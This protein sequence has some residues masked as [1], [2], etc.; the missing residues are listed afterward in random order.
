M[1]SFIVYLKGATGVNMI[2][3]LMWSALV[4]A[5]L[6]V[7]S[8]VLGQLPDSEQSKQWTAQTRIEKKD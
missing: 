8:W 7:P 5:L 2:C 3:H 4:T 1:K 6:A